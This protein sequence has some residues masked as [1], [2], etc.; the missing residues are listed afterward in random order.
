MKII[1]SVVARLAYKILPG[2]YKMWANYKILAFQQGQWRSVRE[3]MAVDVNGAAIPWYTYP[4][5]EYLKSFDF[6][7]CDVFE[8]GSGNSSLYWAGRAKSVVSVEDDKGWFEV[9]SKRKMP[10]QLLIHRSDE[11]GYVNALAE[12]NRRFDIIVIDGSWRKQ[13][14]L[15]AINCLKDDGMIVLDN[16]DRVV[17]LECGRLLRD[18]SFIQIDFSGFGPINGYC[19]TTSIFMRNSSGLQKNYSGPSPVG[20][21]GN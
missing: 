6:K 4:A 1:K 21:L 14:A 9:V 5:I 3:C 8:F 20:G 7:G 16:S 19:W 2:G 17:E 12:Q 10:N 11:S 13:C 18:N 15:G